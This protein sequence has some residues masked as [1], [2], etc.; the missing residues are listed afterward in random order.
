M[1]ESS[2]IRDSS[3]DQSDA[4]P[5]SQSAINRSKERGKRLPA[6]EESNLLIVRAHAFGHFGREAII[7][8]L[9]KEEG[10]W[11]PNLAQDV[12]NHL[13]SCDP[14]LRYTVI[15]A[16]FH[17]L[18]SPISHLP[19]L[20]LQLDLSTS[21]P[22]AIDGSTV[23]MVIICLFSGFVLL[24]PLKDKS[25]SAVAQT[26]LHCVSDFGLPLSIAT[27]AGTEFANIVIAALMAYLQVEQ[28]FAAPYN[29][30]AK[31]KVERVIGTVLPSILKLLRGSLT[32]WVEY[33]PF[34]QLAYNSK[35]ATLTGSAPFSLM[36]GRSA[37]ASSETSSPT[38]T[39]ED[40]Q[41]QQHRV[42]NLVFPSIVNKIADKRVVE[43]K[44][45]IQHHRTI[46][47]GYYPAGAVVML[48]DP[49]KDTK[50]QPTYVGPYT[51]AVRLT[52]GTYILRD[53]EGLFL[54]RPVPAAHLKL[55]IRKPSAPLKHSNIDDPIYEVVQI[56]NHRGDNA[57]REYLTKW[58]GF[59]DPTWVVESNFLD[60]G[61]I[62]EYWRTKA[63]SYL[64][65]QDA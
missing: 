64:A 37:F 43:Q 34:A 26:L 14:C 42:H 40:W 20:N 57:H 60:N 24:R 35:I 4:H 63:Q 1:S 11:W 17:P 52:S 2:A 3:S 53:A 6:P 51:I 56:L 32:L 29:P 46:P 47:D 61:V 19:W 28:N 23:L 12:D 49:H 36:F 58:R 33:L 27:D 25:A 39:L 41:A 50:M 62:A 54:N 16:G 18:S 7:K 21:L 59:E 38:L 10:V 30:R 65:S 48:R 15:K 44:N 8:K 31:G 9:V 55:V 22:Q 13:K 45:F 5:T